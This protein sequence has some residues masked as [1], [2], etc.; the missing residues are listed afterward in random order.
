MLDGPT[1][2]QLAQEAWTNS[3][4]DALADDDP[5][6]DT[7]FDIGGDYQKFWRSILPPGLSREEAEKTS[8]DW[9]DHTLQEGYYQEMNLRLQ[10]EMIKLYFIWEVPTAMSRGFLLEMISRDTMLE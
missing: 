5:G 8:T 6:N 2:L 9:I 10:A 3:Y 4:E 1:Y 7:R